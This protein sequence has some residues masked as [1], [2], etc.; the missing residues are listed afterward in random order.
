MRRKLRAETAIELAV[1][2]LAQKI[3]VHRPER[4]PEGVSVDV[5]RGSLRRLDLD[6]IERPLLGGGDERFEE[7]A[8]APRQLH[9]QFAVAGQRAHRQRI[10]REHPDGP[11]VAGQVRPEHRKGIA[12]TRRVDRVDVDVLCSPIL[13]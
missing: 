10:G 2:S 4:R 7:V 1:R 11:A 13:H 9:E 6:A 5:G 8:L 12:A 3:V